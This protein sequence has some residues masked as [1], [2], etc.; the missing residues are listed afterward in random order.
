M[1]KEIVVRAP[2]AAAWAVLGER[3]GQI[4]EW[5]APITASSLE[6]ALGVGA[7]R[8]CHI[9]GF[10]PVAPGAIRERL[11]DFFA[12]RFGAALATSFISAT[13]NKS[14]PANGANAESARWQ[15]GGRGNAAMQW[16]RVK[17]T[18]RDG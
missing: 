8:T 12:E 10:G 6:G 15:G 14:T 13:S 3:F 17:A 4:A 2:A 5:A 11:I 16:R 1:Y 7:V 18:G 9:A